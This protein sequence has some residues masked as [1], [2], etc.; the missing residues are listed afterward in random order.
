MIKISSS[1]DQGGQRMVVTVNT[2]LIDRYYP[3]LCG[4]L[5]VSKTC[6]R[7]IQVEK[8]AK[9]TAIITFPIPKSNM[10]PIRNTPDGNSVVGID[11]SFLEPLLKELNRFAS[12][13]VRNMSKHVEFLP[14]ND[15]SG[16]YSEEERRSDVVT[17]IKNKRDFLLL[18][19][20]KTYKEEVEAGR[21]QFKQVLV[22]Y[23]TSDYAD[24]SIWIEKNNLEPLKKYFKDNAKVVN[25]F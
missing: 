22:K 14:I 10:G 16:G 11:A 20:Y 13:S 18:D 6:P 21:Y 4:M 12:L 7:G 25:W 1:V 17:A 3:H 23:G 8:A 24:I 15:L 9:D 19:S 2:N 5:K